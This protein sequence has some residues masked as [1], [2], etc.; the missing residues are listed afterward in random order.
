VFEL[1]LAEKFN[2]S[3]MFEYDILGNALITNSCLGVFMYESTHVPPSPWWPSGLR[4]S[5]QTRLYS[6]AWVRTPSKAYFFFAHVDNAHK[7][8]RLLTVPS[9]FGRQQP[10]GCFGSFDLPRGQTVHFYFWP[11]FED[12]K[13]SEKK[14]SQDSTTD[15]S[16]TM[17]L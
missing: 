8:V 12:P 4:R 9:F 15:R 3:R 13:F 17:N 14:H 16:P 5:S 11:K 10:R 1:L 2:M 7:E 6:Y